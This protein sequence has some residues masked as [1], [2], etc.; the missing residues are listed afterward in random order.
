M[1]VTVI[2]EPDPGGHRFQAVANVARL[3]ART[4]EVIL[5]TTAFA[6]STPEFQTFLRHV[7]LKLDERFSDIYPPTRQ[8]LLAVTELCR[9]ND[10][11][12]VVVMDADK[13]LKRW[14]Y[15]APVAFRGVRRRPRIIFFLTRYPARVPLTDRQGWLMRASKA[16]LSLLAM[17]TGSL[18]RVGGFTG[19]DDLSTGWVVKRVRDPAVC[20]AHSRDRD[21]IRGELGIP[22]HRRIVGI[23]GVIDSRKSAPLVLEATL[24]S[25]VDADLLLAGTIHAEVQDWLATLPIDARSR[26]ILREGFLPDE[27][28]DQLVAATNVVTVAQINKGPSGIMGKALAAGVPVVSAGSKVRARELRVTSGGIAAELTAT[29]IAAA[30]R[31][32]YEQGGAAIQASATP[33]ATGETFAATLLGAET[34]SLLAVNPR[35]RAVVRA[36]VMTVNTPVAKTRLNRSLRD[37]PH[38]LRLEIGGLR[39]RPGWVVTN[40]NAVTRNYLD[41]TS[42]WPLEDSS[43]S[44]VYADNVIEHIPLHAARAMLAEAHRCMQ[45]GGVI[46]LVTP[47]IR[48]HV[49][50]YLAGSASVDGV[51]G[52]AYR[53]LGLVVAHPIDLLRIPIGQ[54]GHHSGY[55]YDFE[56]LV[57]E[58][59]RAGFGSVT[60]H[61]LGE[62]AH[63]ELA[64]L[65]QRTDEGGAQIAV[66]AL[67]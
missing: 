27:V 24:A 29:S 66:E 54:F 35:F 13:S 7:P 32:L 28:L 20:T 56:T 65:D 3:A 52:Q 67:R 53:E 12:T 61:E 43:V 15:L 1:P 26:V 16:T 48:K 60:Q 51:V 59:E 14:W 38:P 23:L 55:V 47:D 5:L 57:H 42:R 6:T 18:H 40:V 41:A 34:G 39:K 31:A 44:H 62:S 21:I 50:L 58:L 2:V 8:L 4:G 10:V 37:A 11:S 63:T 30:L 46:R 22:T 36:L 64:G 25:G 45:P 33:P 9:T 19:R 17:A 49:D